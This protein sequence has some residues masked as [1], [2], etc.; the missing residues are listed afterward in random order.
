MK[1]TF[2]DKEH[3]PDGYLLVMFNGGDFICSWDA[4]NL[5]VGTRFYLGALA[6]EC[7]GRLSRETLGL[8]EDVPEEE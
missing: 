6:A 5:D 3:E 8:V 2:K 1:I 4:E 7:V